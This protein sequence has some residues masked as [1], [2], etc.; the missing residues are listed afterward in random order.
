MITSYFNTIYDMPGLEFNSNVESAINDSIVELRGNSELEVLL[1]EFTQI[2]S[3]MDE[4]MQLAIVGKISSSKSTLV[5]A[6]LGESEVV[7]TG[8]MEETW[9]VS[10]LKY[11]DSNSDIIVHYKDGKEE[12]VSRNRWSEWA[13][14]DRGESEKLKN[15][16]SYIEVAYNNEILKTINI[17]DTPG[18]DSFY[19]TDSQNTI[20]FLNKVNPDAVIMLFSK[21]ISADTLSVIEEFR[22]GVG[23]GLS[24]INAMGVMSKIDNIWASDPDLIPLKEAKKISARLMSV[25]NVK[26]TLFD[27]FPISALVA[28]SAS[29]I[30]ESDWRL[31]HELAKI[32]ED[33]WEDMLVTEKR[34]IEEY[35]DVPISVHERKEIR[36]KFGRYAI[37]LIVDSINRD[38]NISLDNA[39]EELLN[40]SGFS[41]FIGVVKSHF[42]ERSILIKSYSLIF[43]LS[44]KCRLKFKELSSKS[45]NPQAAAAIVKLQ[46]V[47]GIVDELIRVLT[48]EFNVV[49]VMKD[50]Y[51]GRIRG[52]K[53]GELEELRRVNGEF[54]SSCIE[55]LDLDKAEHP[56]VL[57]QMASK[58]LGHWVVQ[59]NIALSIAPSKAKLYKLIISLYVELLAE[60][61]SAAYKYESS[62]NF[63]FGDLL[64]NNNNE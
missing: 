17:I 31:F 55:R 45:D 57:M 33:T 47:I 24:P 25:E 35:N 19:G 22:Q 7:R 61:K 5:N 40:K 50:V 37:S 26:N 60:I 20:D 44:T 12:S 62:S 39:R 54:G 18:L 29:I 38:G 58:R 51:E 56:S 41:D 43:S 34:F 48:V 30:S 46:R 14:R 1:K 53:S 49:G 42:G 63:L 3:K 4:P 23:A 6:M 11:G 9:N 36:D 21:S 28:L 10:W 13:N 27:I 32:D 15:I 59:Y 64:N 8:E 16:V 52:V 2:S